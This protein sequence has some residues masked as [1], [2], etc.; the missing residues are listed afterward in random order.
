MGHLLETLL[1][2]FRQEQWVYTQIED[3]PI[4]HSMFTGKNGRLP[5]IAEVKED[6]DMVVFYSYCPVKAPEN[7]RDS[8]AEFL[9]RANYGLLVGNF[10]MDYSDGEVRY[11]TVIARAGDFLS[12]DLISHLVYTNLATMDRYLPGLMGVIYGGLSPVQAV[13]QVEGGQTNIN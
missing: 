10:E 5:F 3:E 8:V 11:K 13:V 2:Y 7:T 9:T 1:D 6:L 4:L 12:K